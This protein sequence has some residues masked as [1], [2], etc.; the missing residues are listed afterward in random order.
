MARDAQAAEEKGRI[1][2]MKK[3]TVDGCEKRHNAHGLCSMHGSRLERTGSV[4]GVRKQSRES[5]PQWKGHAVS[6]G[7]AHRRVYRERGRA[8]DQI[9]PCGSKAAH[10]AYDHA[11]PDELTELTPGGIRYY[12]PDPTHY[13]AMCVPCHKKSDLTH[14]K[15]IA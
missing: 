5:H 10:W 8:T 7:G 15:E 2:P 6:Y 9:C 14:I 12:S 11:D 3:C 13:V 1:I 4:H